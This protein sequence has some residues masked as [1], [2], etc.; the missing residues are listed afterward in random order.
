MT[1]LLAH[2]SADELDALHDGSGN[3]RATS[4]LETCA[5]CRAMVASDLSLIATLSALPSWDP[6]AGFAE[7]II[8][9]LDRSVVPVLA[10]TPAGETDRSRSARRRVLIGGLVVGGVV[11]GGFAWAAFNP[12]AALDLATPALQDVGQALW[13]SLQALTANAVEQPWFGAV[14]DTLASPSR[15]VPA[16]VGAGLAYAV[17]LI[18]LRRLLTRPAADAGW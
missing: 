14:R 7:R 3:E 8:A 9:G 16:L 10:A 2:L 15:V 12:G 11:S 6:R 1:D 18:G 5:D 4:H 13:L 17:A